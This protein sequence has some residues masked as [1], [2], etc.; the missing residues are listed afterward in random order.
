MSQS[1]LVSAPPPPPSQSVSTEL[2]LTASGPSSHTSSS[3]DRTERRRS[4]SKKNK[5]L[6]LLSIS[7]SK[8]LQDTTS[9]ESI[10]T[11]AEQQ[12]QSHHNETQPQ[13]SAP[14]QEQSNNRPL[15]VERDQLIT[16]PQ[17]RQSTLPYDEALG[18]LPPGWSQQVAQT[19]RLFFIDHNNRITTWVDPRTNKPTP[20]PQSQNRHG[21]GENVNKS[22]HK[23]STTAD[24][25]PLPP[26]WEERVHRDGRIFFIDHSK[27]Y[28]E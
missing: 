6:T 15:N 19:G 4:R 3:F 9:L 11:T 25:G 18:P 20:S 27:F 21:A 2:Y 26:G 10:G 28:I 1:T 7:H 14:E 16:G 22:D 23:S 13:P 12:Q 24:I 17:I 8:R 5:F